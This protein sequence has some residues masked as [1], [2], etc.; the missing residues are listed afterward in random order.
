[1]SITKKE[2]FIPRA[3]Y[4]RRFSNTRNH[5]DKKNKLMAYS[6]SENRCYQT[7][8]YDSACVNSIY[9]ENE[10]EKNAIEKL[11]NVLEED[12][13]TFFDMLESIC[14]NP[15]NQHALILHN[16]DERDSL[17]FFVVWQLYRTEKRRA[18]DRQNFGEANEGNLA[19]LKRLIGRD[20][21]GEAILIKWKNLLEN[22]YFVFERNTT[23]IPFILPDDP[24]FL[25]HS[26][27][28]QPN[29]VNFRFPL[30]PWIQILLIDPTSSEHIWA[31]PFR[32]RIRLVSDPTYIQSWNTK[33]IEESYRN[34]YYT[35]NSGTIRD[36]VFCP[37]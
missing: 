4:L 9:E 21:N 3:A 26:E 27:S 35:P 15:A 6:V 32:N 30:T 2:H 37:L 24:V 28:D 1:M 29:T 5:D 11:F 7:N 25:F 18:Q 22:H 19:F 20:E 33:G 14:L 8:V 10:I 31:K 36:G 12:L 13:A 16:T 34:V 23:N 17:K